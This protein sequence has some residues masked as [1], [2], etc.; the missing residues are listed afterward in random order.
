ML[1]GCLY[2]A[3]YG[4]GMST[5]FWA[6]SESKSVPDHKIRPEMAILIWKS[7]RAVGHDG[8]TLKYLWNLTKYVKV[9]IITIMMI[10]I[11]WQMCLWPVSRS[12]PNLWPHWKSFVQAESNTFLLFI[13]QLRVLVCSLRHTS[14]LKDQCILAQGPFTLKW[15]ASQPSSWQYTIMTFA[16]VFHKTHLLSLQ[17]S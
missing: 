17:F 2:G 12:F 16:K 4:R 3:L 15:P 1:R 13:Q 5:K 6:W 9:C 11:V 14:H 8:V 10:V 7:W